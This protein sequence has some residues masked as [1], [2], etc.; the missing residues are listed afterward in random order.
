MKKTYAWVYVADS[1][2]QFVTEVY[3]PCNEQ[4]LGEINANLSANP[5][6]GFPRNTAEVLC[7]IDPIAPKPLYPSELSETLYIPVYYDCI[8]VKPLKIRKAEKTLHFELQAISK[9]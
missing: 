4:M 6:E 1:Q 3:G 9:K 8:P 7:L 5:L 2:S